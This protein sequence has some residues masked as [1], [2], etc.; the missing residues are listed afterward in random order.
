MLHVDVEQSHSGHLQPLQM[1]AE[2]ICKVDAAKEGKSLC[3][4]PFLSQPG[5]GAAS[6]L[7]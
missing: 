4:F 5:Q 2:Q 3:F 6:F 1:P 7:V